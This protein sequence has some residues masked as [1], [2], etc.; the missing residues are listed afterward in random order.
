MKRFFAMRQRNLIAL[1]MAAQGLVKTKSPLALFYKRIKS[2]IG[3]KGAITATAHKLASLVYRMLK[4]GK[5]YVKQSLEE[6]ERK[7]KDQLERSLRRKASALGY[8]L[9]AK[10]AAQPT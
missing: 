4:Y 6:Y 2:R 7:I 1:R 5:E 10:P 8:E 9:V 3:G